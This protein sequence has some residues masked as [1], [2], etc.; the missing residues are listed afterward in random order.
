MC[1]DLDTPSLSLMMYESALAG[2]AYL[3]IGI[4]AGIAEARAERA[5]I[6]A[7]VE[8]NISRSRVLVG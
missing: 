1:D 3:V 4:A 5:R 6:D 8:M 2:P 7:V